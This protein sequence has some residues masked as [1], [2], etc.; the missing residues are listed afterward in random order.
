MNYWLGGYMFGAKYDNFDVF[1][2]RSYWYC[3]DP[4]RADRDEEI[5]P[6]AK[7]LFPQIKP[8]DRIAMKRILGLGKSGGSKEIEV[9]AIGIVTDMDLTEWRCY[10]KWILHYPDLQRIVPSRGAL[11]ALNGPYGAD[12]PWIRTI[13]Q[14]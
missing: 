14:I 7:R 6:K 10:V 11:S 13:F 2:R 5:S 8:G 3:W 9:R 1:I 12:N 4:N